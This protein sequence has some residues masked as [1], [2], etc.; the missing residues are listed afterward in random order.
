MRRK[1]ELQQRQLIKQIAQGRCLT[2]HVSNG[3]GQKQ[4][5]GGSLPLRAHNVSALH[6]VIPKVPST[7]ER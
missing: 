2:L 5:E 3:C 1:A 4:T 7:K 6:P